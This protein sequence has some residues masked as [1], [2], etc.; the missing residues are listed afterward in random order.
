MKR[1][2]LNSLI[3]A[4]FA[5]F[6]V[7]C[8]PKKVIIA[9]PSASAEKVEVSADKKPENLTLLKSKDLPFNTLS[10]KG[11]ASL[12]VNGDVNNVTMNIRIQ[13]DKKIWVSVTGLAGIEGVRAVIT[14]DS[15]LLR[16]NLQK[17]FTK[18]PFNYI[19]GFTNKQVNFGMLQAVL[20]GNTIND[21]MVEKSDLVQENGVWVLSGNAQDLAYRILF[22]TLLKPTEVNLNDAKN[23]QAFKVAYGDYTPINSSLFPSSLKINSMAGAKKINISI[24]FIKIESNVAVEFPFSVPK[25]F[26]LVN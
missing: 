3:L 19:Y 6:A 13:K 21:F 18:K 11:K 20:S 16:N 26:E 23:A 9:T 25:N 2:I 15:L 12:D 4:V 5:T 7:G 22:N 17:T 8:R 14:P 1:N 10:L 24:E